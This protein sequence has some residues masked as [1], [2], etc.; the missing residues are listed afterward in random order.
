MYFWNKCDDF[1]DRRNTVFKYFE[2]LVLMCT[3]FAS[4]QLST[5]E[6]PEAYPPHHQSQ[7]PHYQ[8]QRGKVWYRII[9]PGHLNNN[10]WSDMQYKQLGTY[11][12]RQR[13]LTI[14]CTNLALMVVV[15]SLDP[16]PG[17]P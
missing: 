2:K 1:L 4:H 5:M 17:W 10:S 14:D 15:W 13:R 8:K 12:Q 3:K 16:P 9:L 7:R 6:G 11:E